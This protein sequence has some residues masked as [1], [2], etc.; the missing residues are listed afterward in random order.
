MSYTAIDYRVADGIAT[1]TLSRPEKLNAFSY[2]MIDEVLDA[3][4]RI[5]ADDDVRAVIFTGAGRAFSAGTDISDGTAV[6]T[7]DD[8]QDALRKP[9]GSFDYGAEAARDGGGL[10]SLRL[11]DCLKPVIAAINGPAVGIGATITLAM[12]IRLASESAGIGFVFARRGI[13][14]EAASAFFL[15][16]LVGIGQALD[17]CYSGKVVPAAEAQAA[18]LVKAVYP[19]EDLL[20]AARAI[21]REIAD[22]TAP[23]AVALIR[24]MMWRGL[25]Y[26]HPMEAHRVDSRGILARGSSADVAEGV[27]AFLEKRPA[28]FVDRVSTDMPD[29]FPWWSEPSYR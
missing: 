2:R 7:R 25:G 29:F 18:G 5:D 3:L 15:P 4:D 13:V 27:A 19:P 1:V 11:F 26:S 10:I 21:A 12:D 24:Q 28:R 8:E 9:D 23:V 16:R 17:W 6:F 22:R 20:P 14:P